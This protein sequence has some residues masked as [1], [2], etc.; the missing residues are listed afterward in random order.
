[1]RPR[2]RPARA[3][4]V[5]SHVLLR[6]L[7]LV[8]VLFLL[9]LLPGEAAATGRAFLQASL[10]RGGGGASTPAATTA[11]SPRLHLSF[12]LLRRN[13]RGAQVLTALPAFLQL[14]AGEAGSEAPGFQ[15]PLNLGRYPGQPPMQ[16]DG[17]EGNGHYYSGNY[18]K[19]PGTFTEHNQMSGREFGLG[20]EEAV[21][22]AA[23]RE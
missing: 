2:R 15:E 14:A 22:V 18:N 16:N 17:T 13:S 5:R 10:W 1:M 11:S 12:H 8:L 21:K 20:T 23:Q 7:L 4:V 6:L 19:A 3:D 9:L